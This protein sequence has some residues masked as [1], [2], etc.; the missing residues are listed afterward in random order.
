MIDLHPIADLLEAFRHEAVDGPTLYRGIMG[1][2][3]WIVPGRR[4]DDGAIELGILR[5]EGDGRILELFSGP[6]AVETFEASQGE[7]LTEARLTLSGFE[8]FGALEE[9]MVDRINL[10]PLSA[11]TCHFFHNQVPMLRAWAQIGA[12]ETALQGAGRHSDPV[13]LMAHYGHFHMV[14]L[15]REDGEH[16]LVLAPD[17]R[18]RSLGAIFTTRELAVEFALG[19]ADEMERPPAVIPMTPQVMFERLASMTLQGIVFNPW[20]SLEPRAMSP[21]LIQAVLDRLRA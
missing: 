17:S 1:H 16:D 7:P 9:S 19:I 10:D 6:R 18:E 13:G 4:T 14:G 12:L 3:G 11:H 2:D 15:P 5:T 21:A 8:I 20:T